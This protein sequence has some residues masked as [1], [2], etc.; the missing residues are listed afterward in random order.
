MPV[1][2][3]PLLPARRRAA[4]AEALGRAALALQRLLQVCTGT[5]AGDGRVGVRCRAAVEGRGPQRCAA[6]SARAECLSLSPTHARARTH[7]QNPA[8][9]Q[10]QAW[11]RDYPADLSWPTPTLPDANL[12]YQDAPDWRK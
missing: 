5:A 3:L 2:C 11:S 10:G 8:R 4:A 1:P 7:T 9:W 12:R 6:R